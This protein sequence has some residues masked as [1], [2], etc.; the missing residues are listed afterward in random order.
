MWQ[1]P[2]KLRTAR[3]QLWEWLLGEGTVTGAADTVVI[4]GM[5]GGIAGDTVVG[6]ADS[7]GAGRTVLAAGTTVIVGL[8]DGAV[9]VVAADS[10]AGDNVEEA[11]R[12]GG[13][14]TIGA[15]VASVTAVGAGEILAGTATTVVPESKGSY[16]TDTNIIMTMTKATPKSLMA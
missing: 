6:A 10:T 2:M 7:V 9:A 14:V 12:A 8:A 5:V 15:V 11:I 4:V 3:P 13:A 16:L 1:R